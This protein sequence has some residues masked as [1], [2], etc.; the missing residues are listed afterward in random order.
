VPHTLGHLQMLH[1]VTHVLDATNCWNLIEGVWAWK[2]VVGVRLVGGISGMV[3][4]VVDG[5]IGAGGWACFVL[6][7]TLSIDPSM[8]MVVRTIV[9]GCEEWFGSH[10]PVAVLVVTSL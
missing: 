3:S 6:S 1:S 7:S 10:P 4:I 9:M 8:V 2:M 5:F